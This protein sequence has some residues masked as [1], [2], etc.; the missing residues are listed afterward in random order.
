MYKALITT[1]NNLSTL[2]DI[3]RECV[4]NKNIS[5]C[6]HLIE[7]VSSCYVYNKEFV[8]EKEY[9]LIIKCKSE[10]TILINDVIDRLHNYDVPEVISFEFD[11]LSEKYK[12]WFNNNEF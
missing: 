7:G 8:D 4:L 6:V 9:V 10:N 2:K 11:I 1:S 5:P 3:A 12:E